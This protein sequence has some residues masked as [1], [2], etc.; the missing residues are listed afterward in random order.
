MADWNAWMDSIN[1]VERG[2]PFGMS[3]TVYPDG[4]VVDHGGS[5]PASGYTI[6]EATSKGEAIAMSKSC[7][8]LASK[9]SIEIC[10][11]MAM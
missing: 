7:P 1:I 2:A 4:T 8:I 5:N 11:C 9:G 10:E 6:I 3:S